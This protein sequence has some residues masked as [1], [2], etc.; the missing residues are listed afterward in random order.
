M[1]D[2]FRGRVRSL[3]LFSLF[4]LFILSLLLSFFFAFFFFSLSLCFAP[5]AFTSSYLHY[6]MVFYRLIIII[7]KT[8]FY[9]VIISCVLRF[10]LLK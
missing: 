7:S 2:F 9:S 5:L 6:I 1:A 10:L 8:N 4:F 3:F